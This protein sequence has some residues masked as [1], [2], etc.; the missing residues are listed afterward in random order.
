M[1]RIVYELW[2]IEGFLLLI[3]SHFTS[4]IWG[5]VFLVW[6]VANIVTGIIFQSKE[7]LKEKQSQKEE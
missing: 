4:G 7:A 6:G 3:L 1:K 2:E 5:K